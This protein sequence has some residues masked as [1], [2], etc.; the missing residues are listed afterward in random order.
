MSYVAMFLQLSLTFVVLH[1]LITVPVGIVAGYIGWREPKRSDVFVLTALGAALFFGMPLVPGAA[2]GQSTEMIY[3]F[4]PIF[5]PCYILLSYG[6]GTAGK[7][8]FRLSLEGSH[9]KRRLEIKN[10]QTPLLSLDSQYGLAA[11][12]TY[13]TT[14]IRRHFFILLNLLELQPFG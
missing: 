14:P 3:L 6:L 7:K 13:P 1:A 10:F 4:L 8:T 12:I 11:E 2:H 5:V 9:V